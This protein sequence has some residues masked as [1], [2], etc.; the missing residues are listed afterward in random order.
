MFSNQVAFFLLLHKTVCI[1]SLCRISDKL[2]KNYHEKCVCSH[3]QNPLM[4]GKNK[5]RLCRPDWRHGD[6]TL[7]PSQ[8]LGLA[9]KRLVTGAQHKEMTCD[10]S[11]VAHHLQESSKSADVMWFGRQLK[12]LRPVAQTPVKEL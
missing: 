9:G 4:K 1:N 5:A 3:I 7:E 8:G 10:H 6:P 11:P 2:Y 12:A